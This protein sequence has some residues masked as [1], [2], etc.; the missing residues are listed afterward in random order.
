MESFDAVLVDDDLAGR[1]RGSAK[2]ELHTEPGADRDV[3]NG[4]R[5]GC[6]SP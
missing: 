4:A 2:I 1:V 6:C 5:L 3:G